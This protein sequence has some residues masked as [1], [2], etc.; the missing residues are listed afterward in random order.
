MKM[1]LTSNY[2]VITCSP[3]GL[4]QTQVTSC[5]KSMVSCSDL[6]S[7]QFHIFIVLSQDPETNVELVGTGAKANDDTG[8]S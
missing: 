3:F 7:K 5:N 6:V 2:F 4:K 8:A 1:V